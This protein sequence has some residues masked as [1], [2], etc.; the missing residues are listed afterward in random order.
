MSVLF[1]TFFVS[2]ACN[3]VILF[4]CNMLMY[5][6]NLHIYGGNEEWMNRS[7]LLNWNYKYYLGLKHNK[8]VK[9]VCRT[10]NLP[11]YCKKSRQICRK[12]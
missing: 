11:I 9:G 10:Q 1:E 12:K 5:F 8:T 3:N 6:W 2:T 4:M 7:M